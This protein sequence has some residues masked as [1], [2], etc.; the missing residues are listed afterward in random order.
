MVTLIT[1]PQ[2]IFFDSTGSTHFSRNIPSQIANK[3]G[4]P[5]TK[6]T[7]K[8]VKKSQRERKSTRSTLP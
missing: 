3:H 2:H 1:F 7:S 8:E 4:K 5:P 6:Q